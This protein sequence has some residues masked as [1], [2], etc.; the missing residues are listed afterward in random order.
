MVYL[1]L[2]LAKFSS[3]R[4]IRIISAI[5]IGALI[6]ISSMPSTTAASVMPSVEWS[7]TYSG[8]QATSVIQTSDGGYAIAGTSWPIAATFV[9]IDSA[10]NLQWQK[11]QG[12]ILSVG[13]T[14]DSGYVLFF[15]NHIV[16]TNDEGD[17]ES[18]FSTDYTGV[19]KGIL[20]HEGNYVLVG[21]S[22]ADN[23]EDFAW[24]Q[25]LDRQ[26]NILW[27][28]TFTG[29]FTVYDVTETADRG[30][31]LAGKWR[32]DFW[33]AKIDANS[34][35]QWSQTYSYGDPSDLHRVNSVVQTKDGGFILAGTGEWQ[36][37]GRFVPWLIKINS[38][39]HA[40]WSLPY[41]HISHD[42][43]TAVVQTDD[44]G[45]ILAL[46]SSGKLLRT[47]T[48]GSELWKLTLDKGSD[49]WSLQ[50]NS[51]CLIRTNDGGYLVAGTVFSNTGF[52]TKISSEPDLHP[53][54]VTVLSPQSKSY[55]TNEV[56]LVFTVNKP[57]SWIGYSLNGQNE[58]TITGNTTLSGLA[59]GTHNVT[60]YAQD[61]EG[62]VG[63]SETIQFTIVSRFPTELVIISI[64]TATLGGL[65]FLVYMKRKSFSA[66]KKR[67]LGSFFQKQRF[68]VLAK[69]RI[70]WTLTIMALSIL[71]VFFQFFFPYV[72]YSAT[73][74]SINSSFE[75]G[76]SYVY[77]QDSILQVYDEVARIKDLGFSVIRVNMVCNSIDPSAYVNTL[78]E[79]FFSAVRQIDIK[80][81][82]IINNHDKV[83]DINYYLQNWGRYLTYVQILNEPDVASSWDMGAL[84]TDD[85][86]GSRFEEIYNAVAQH[87]LPV[88]YYT[89]F[90]PAFIAR[91]NLPVQFS[92]KLDFIGYDVFMESFL[93][94]SPRMIQILQK[95]TDKE[96]V[97]AEFGMSTSDD[98]A[99]ADY[100]I[101][102]LNLFK[103]MDLMGC[104]IVYWNS[105]DNFYGIRGRLAE[106]KV[107]DWIAQNL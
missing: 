35:L 55:E 40:Q 29:G 38:Q 53:P 25:K 103:N 49:G 104:W 87:Q 33:L 26:G 99:Q 31:A 83:D 7:Q 79:V 51:S 36:A 106:Q 24:L 52:V 5:A 62:I 27:N 54:V 63:T 45:Y 23:G 71:L 69:N 77:E 76:I 96:I 12:N 66:Y 82:L 91:T 3:M 78:T 10:G 9:K 57:V 47:D 48:S 85:E 42:S 34:N 92:E 81:A 105:V 1:K 13:Q 14:E 101:R 18:S 61:L 19:E 93:T 20:T 75:V 4:S 98:T 84:F 58:V 100:I 73:S 17:F 89:N 86:A 43:F 88:K 46:G 59:I 30:C 64:A 15:R 39:G 107:G 102:G 11:A 65:V 28:Q 41:D 50:Y 67:G 16:K 37:R 94:L 72:Y 21:N 60:V 80:I 68:A 44:E 90:T 97:I 95:I 56:P 6:L 74:G 2:W 8:L 32:N 22:L 70:L